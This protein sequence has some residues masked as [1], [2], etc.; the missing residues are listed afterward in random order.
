MRRKITVITCIVLP[1][2]TGD[3]CA[4]LYD[5]HF[6]SVDVVRTVFYAL[7]KFHVINSVWLDFRILSLQVLILNTLMLLFQTSSIIT[8]W[9]IATGEVMECINRLVNNPIIS[10]FV[11][12]ILEWNLCV[13]FPF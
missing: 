10:F 11:S 4:V 8:S 2:L 13:A 1:D 3:T 7:R 5:K 6:R 12:E 9:T